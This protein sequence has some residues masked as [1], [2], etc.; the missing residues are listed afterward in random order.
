[1]AYTTQRTIRLTVIAADGLYKRD[2]FRLPDP[3]AVVT[4]DGDQ[5][6]T[7]TVMKKTLNPYWNESFEVNVTNKSI[8]AVQ[9]FDQK[10]F[11]KKD[12]GFLG[13]VNIQMGDVFDV[14]NGGDE[15]LT[16]E[17]KKS[18]ANDVV[19]QG[20]LILNISSNISNQSINNQSISN[21]ALQAVATSHQRTPSVISAISSNAG[22]SVNRNSMQPSPMAL[23]PSQPNGAT[24]P[25]PIAMPNTAPNGRQLSPY[26]DQNGPL[27]PNWERR[28]DMLGR[29][30][31]VDHNNRTTTWTRP[32]LN[33]STPERSQELSN[34]TE[35]ERRQHN[36]RALPEE[37]SG[38]SSPL[39]G[40]SNTS[41]P[42]PAANSSQPAVAT[43][44]PGVAPISL[45][46]TT[47]GSGPL[48]AGWEQRLTPEGR[49]YYVDHNTRATTW[50]DPR[51]QQYVRMSDPR[52]ATSQVSV[53]QQPVSQLGALPSG[54]EMRLT[55][56][57][58]VYFVDH[59][60][61]TTTWDDP[62]LPS[63][64][65][66]N[67]PQY[68]RDFRR[69]LIYFR[70][71]PA[72]RPVPG[73]CHIKVRRSHIFEDAYHEIMRQSPTDLK[74]RLMI[75]FEGEDGLDYGGLSREF[76]FLLSHEMFNPF[77]CLFEYSAHDNYTLQINPHSSINSEHLNYFKFIGRVVGLAIFHRRLLD[78]FFIVSFYK[79]ILKKKVTLADLESVDADVYR[80]LNW[81][82]D[83]ETGAE[84]LD[85]TFST[86]DER[87]G[88]IVTIDLK[89]NGQNIE[90][91]EENKREYVDLMTEWRI[92]RRFEEQFKAFAEGFHQLIPQELVTVF[93][94]RELELLMGG[95]SEID[96]DDW[97]KHTD[98]R[99]YTEQDEVVQWFWKCI[100][101]W[102]SEKKARLLQFTTGTSRIPVNGFKDLQGSDGPRRFTIEKAG[103]IGQLPKSHT[104]FNRI[105]L[106]PYK[107]YD[108]LV[109][110]LTM[111]VEETVGFGQE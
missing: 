55:N 44:A 42:D 109:Q 69:K 68:K 92:T 33:A 6:H 66:Q 85:T 48:P 104:C 8:L 26:E 73:Q 45:N 27:P 12:Q 71:Q 37:R 89:E 15:M 96:C 93:D 77:Y 9:I 52:N 25:A 83:D 1:M 4:V 19:V 91:T 111:A 84:T 16:T 49:P 105:D 65:D 61:K 110:K 99:G 13:T 39:P 20:K 107:S 18:G 54:W 108:V 79:M 11:K 31:Y 35:M 2:V 94:E 53:H 22:S 78:A 46:S 95:I 10:K 67:V 62:R 17:L 100:R 76:F 50:V 3:F 74:K 98:Y 59:N 72:L 43:T 64:L 90:V 40:A 34:Q 57:A 21:R 32:S 97:K 80:N 58:R 14:N 23:S 56:T 38:G 101:S 60:T 87:F 88:E 5:T 30:Y 47:A 63:S 81:L 24:A 41:L 51:R 28:V 103:E 75:K 82:L 29:T 106:P 102:D 70:S 7:T 86:N 36:S